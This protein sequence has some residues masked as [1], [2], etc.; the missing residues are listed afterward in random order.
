MKNTNTNNNSDNNFALENIADN[1]NE[2][3]YDDEEGSHNINNKSKKNKNKNFQNN[4]TKI[5]E[6]QITDLKSLLL[7]RDTEISIL[8]N[9]VNNGKN[10]DDVRASNTEV[11]YNANYK[12]KNHDNKNNSNHRSNDNNDSNDNN[13]DSDAVNDTG[14]KEYHNDQN[15]SKKGSVRGRGREEMKERDGEEKDRERGEERS[16]DRGGERGGERSGEGKQVGTRI[17]QDRNEELNRIQHSNQRTMV[18]LSY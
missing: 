1:R 14:R 2:N 4:G 8:V 7:Q 18:R 12:K 5:Y 15:V 11:N 9:M 6:N 3:L 10:G 13:N 16:G 17:K